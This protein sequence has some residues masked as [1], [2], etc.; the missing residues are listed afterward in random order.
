MSINK[1]ERLT[2]KIGEVIG[3]YK[4]VRMNKNQFDTFEKLLDD[5]LKLTLFT[6]KEL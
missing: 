5:C 3:L 6:L 4:N 1:L 2:K